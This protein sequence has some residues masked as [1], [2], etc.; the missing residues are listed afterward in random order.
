MPTKKQAHQLCNQTSGNWEYYTA[1]IIV[2]AS[3]LVMG[4][5]DLDPASSDI[6]N[7]T[8]KA[9]AYYT[10]E[11]DGLSKDW[12]GNIWLNH[13]FHKGEKACPKLRK[14][15]KKKI[16]KQRGFH[17]DEDIP[18]N[19]KWI[20]KLISEYETNNI[21]Q[22]MSIC[23]A[24]TSENWFFPLLD[25]PQCY[26]NPRTN[27]FDKHGNLIKGVSKGS[28]VTYI[29]P[30]VKLFEEVFEHRLKLGKVKY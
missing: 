19:S 26:L 1:P 9:K 10:I 7:K 14:R 20:N 5:I 28:V 12:L 21:F 4:S 24:S 3:R 29:G 22:A 23:Y 30:K 13:P 17:I 2:H 8:V 27:Y 18:S 6:A 25:F 15:C 16:C 11:D